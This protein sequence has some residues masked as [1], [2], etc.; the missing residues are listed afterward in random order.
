VTHEFQ[1][2]E[3]RRLAAYQQRAATTACTLIAA[4]RWAGWIAFT[5]GCIVIGAYVLGV[6]AIW[7]PIAGGPATSPL[8]AVLFIGGGLAVATMQPLRTPLAPL[9]L[10]LAVALIALGRIFEIAV[11][12]NGLGSVPLFEATRVREVA[13]GTP[14]STGWNSATMFVLVATAF[15]LRYLGWPKA[16]QIAAAAGMAPPLVAITG[17]IYGIDQFHGDMSLATAAIGLPFSATPLLFG[18]RTGIVRAISSPWDGGR[19]GRLQ[20]LLIGSAIFLGGF[21]L[22][23]A[24][25]T[26]NAS[27]FPL[28]V[29]M[30]ILITSTTIAYCSV[31]MERNDQGRRQAERMVTHLVMHDPLSG[32]HNRR[33][34]NEQKDKVVA[35]ARRQQ[36]DVSVMMLDID[37]FKSVNDQYGHPAGDQVIRRLAEALK[38]RLRNTDLPVRY[39]GEEFLAVLLD[40]DF[41]DAMIV[42]EEIRENAAALGFSDLGIRAIT[43]SV[44]VAQVLTT[45]PEAIGRADE[46]LYEAKNSGR[47]RVVGDETQPGPRLVDADNAPALT[48][49]HASVRRSA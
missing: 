16:S 28:F 14:V 45:L 11:D 4:G 12:W 9:S 8:T 2:C 13:E 27:L 36:Y 18:A 47:N 37:H 42:A 26:F 21:A 6:E 22:Q 39:G 25:G 33:F 31:V 34:L 29:V 46:A 32:L 43:V 49:D 40:A 48:G 17:Y 5:G 19:F 3:L 7:R 1:S 35:F 41:D 38:A 10:L 15:L 24:H 23:L 44:G 20:I 30:A